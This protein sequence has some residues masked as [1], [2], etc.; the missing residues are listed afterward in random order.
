MV[1]VAEKG[2]NGSGESSPEFDSE[3]HSKTP[4][5]SGQGAEGSP[6][7]ARRRLRDDR[8]FDDV[9]TVRRWLARRHQR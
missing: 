7:G 5:R 1:S 8:L 6:A 3:T 4:A 2:R 9:L